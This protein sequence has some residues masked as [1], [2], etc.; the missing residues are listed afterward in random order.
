MPEK[1]AS[2]LRIVR[3][4]QE[5]SSEKGSFV[6]DPLAAMPIRISGA[7]KRTRVSLKA[8][9]NDGLCRNTDVQ[10]EKGKVLSRHETW[11]CMITAMPKLRTKRIKIM[12]RSKSP[13]RRARKKANKGK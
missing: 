8:V 3:V 4:Q 5:V 10:E 12:D 2:R 1:A 6:R 11:K 9:G 7:G 13:K